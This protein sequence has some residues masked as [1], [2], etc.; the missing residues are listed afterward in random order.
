MSRL[1]GITR[2]TVYAFVCVCLTL[3]APLTPYSVLPMFIA[4]LSSQWGGGARLHGSRLRPIL[5]R[6]SIYPVYH[7]GHCVSVFVCVCLILPASPIPHYLLPMFRDHRFNLWVGHAFLCQDSVRS[8]PEDPYTLCI[9]R[10]TVCAFVCVCL[11]LHA[12][13]TPSLL[14]PPDVHSPLI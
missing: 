2:N 3:H 7:V 12:P 10:D 4:H 11:T 6:G 14:R 1:L 9:T 8:L 5:A 13:P